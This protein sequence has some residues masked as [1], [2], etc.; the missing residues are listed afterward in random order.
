MPSLQSTMTNDMI[1]EYFLEHPEAER[2]LFETREGHLIQILPF[3]LLVGLVY[4]VTRLVVWR[5]SGCRKTL[6]WEVGTLLLIL[7]LAGVFALW[8]VPREI[9][10]YLWF[11]G[12]FGLW[13]GELVAQVLNFSFDWFPMMS[14]V[15][16][17]EETVWGIVRW[18]LMGNIM[19]FVPLGLITPIFLGERGMDR[20]LKLGIL[21]TALV[22]LV[23]LL[24]G[25]GLSVENITVDLFS[26]GVG[27]CLYRTIR[28]NLA[29]NTFK[30]TSNRGII[31]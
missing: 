5:L 2:F 15:L 9:W 17:G 19:M 4:L 31:R 11:W 16:N 27:L 24:L 25:C 28:D 22:E 12:I 1:R 3:L 30:T 7:Y 26:V 18:A 8:F 21:L 20:T 13:D 10:I 6:L 14:Q 29:E 23:R